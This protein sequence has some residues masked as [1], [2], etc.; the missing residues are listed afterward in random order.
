MKKQTEGETF[1]K[2]A[3][4]AVAAIMAHAIEHRLPTIMS[5]DV[6]Q[7]AQQ[8]NVRVHEGYDRWLNSL[9]LVTETNEPAALGN[10]WWRSEWTVQLPDTGVSF[11]LIAYREQ[12]LQ[13]VSA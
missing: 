2:Q 12:P 6:Y 9:V 3:N 5:I 11:N 10:G 8:L 1:A 4:A 7:G 13:A